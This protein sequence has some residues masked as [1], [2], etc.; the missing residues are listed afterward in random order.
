MRFALAFILLL[1]GLPVM[2]QQPIRNQFTT[3]QAMNAVADG[4]S[5][6]WNATAKMWSNVLVAGAGGDAGGT[7]SRQNG[8]IVLSN[9]VG[10]VANNVTNLKAGNIIWVQT[11]GN[12]ATAERGR[13]D[14]PFADPSAAKAVAITGDLIWIRPG[15]YIN[16][17]ILARNVNYYVEGIISFTD[18]GSDTQAAIFDTRTI[19]NPT[20]NIITGPGR[21]SFTRIDGVGSTDYRSGVLV[22]SNDNNRITIS[23]EEINLSEGVA[24]QDGRIAGVLGLR[25]NIYSKFKRIHDDGVNASYTSAAYWENG[26]MYFDCEDVD[27]DNGYGV[28]AFEVTTNTVANLWIKSQR[29]RARA[30]NGIQV[31]AQATS[32]NNQFKVW[33]TEFGELSGGI[34]P[35]IVNGPADY[36]RGSRVYIESGGKI[37]G[38]LGINSGTVWVSADKHSSG[39]SGNYLTMNGGRLFLFSQHY[40]TL[41]ATAGSTGFDLNGGYANISGGQ[42][43]HGGNPFKQRGGTN[44]IEGLTIDTSAAV[45]ATNVPIQYMGGALTLKNVSL[46][47]SNNAANVINATTAQTLGIAGILNANKPIDSD[48]TIAGTSTNTIVNIR[49]AGLGTNAILITDAGGIIVTGKLSGASMAVDGTLTITGAAAGNS[50]DIQF[51]QGGAFAGTN[52]LK[53]DRTN[54][55]LAIN[56]GTIRPNSAID[57]GGNP[58]LYTGIR[59]GASGTG[60]TNLFD[61]DGLG[62]LGDAAQK[63]YI[64]QATVWYMDTSALRY[65]WHP[66][67]TNSADI[68]TW[69]NPV[70]TN[71][72]VWGVFKDSVVLGGG[73][74]GTGR[75]LIQP[76]NGNPVLQ[77]AANSN[78][79]PVTNI[80]GLVE[81]AAGTPTFLNANQSHQYVQTNRVTAATTFVWTNTAVG[82]EFSLV[83]PG[84]IAGGTS[85]VIT[86]AAGTGGAAS[87]VANLDVFGTAL[88]FT[89]TFTLTNGNAAEINGKVARVHIAGAAPTNVV[90]FVSRQY[91]F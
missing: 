38:P 40:E 43:I 89:M 24:L 44:L 22:S 4:W 31:D 27:M 75:L 87:L 78:A 45:N 63:F 15:L 37:D 1:V 70:D 60:K 41:G 13:E 9:L 64:G 79:V 32:T 28:W 23:G 66:A 52:G 34:S 54:N 30:W 77:K 61:S 12:N 33:L 88:A 55:A 58:N 74:S 59:V 25:G 3:N 18:D 14:K 72:N 71:W 84:E 5:S 11:N 8:S 91:A 65:S 82:Q 69:A 51:N 50:S 76:T 17:D 39:G 47:A 81:L 2:A 21:Y 36:N 67:L 53:W 86:L 19:T 20:T 90:S 62:Q 80:V 7:N 57:I 26:E 49:P 46:V 42:L 85:R 56:Q 29:L 10:T 48:I 83:V 6:V 68:G 73:G 16:N 35:L